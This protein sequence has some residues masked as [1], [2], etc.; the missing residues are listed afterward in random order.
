VQQD[1]KVYKDQQE[2]MVQLDHKAQQETM[3]QQVHK[4]QQVFKDHKEN[5]DQ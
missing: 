1:R 3:A 4:E 5:Q 2:M